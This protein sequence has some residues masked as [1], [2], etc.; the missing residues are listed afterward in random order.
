MLVLGISLMILLLGATGY[1]GEASARELTRRKLN[2]VP[3]SRQDIDYSRFDVLLNYLKT[4][5]PAFVINAAGYTG[6]R[7]WM[8]RDRARRCPGRYTMLPQ[9][10]ARPAPP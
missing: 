4:K 5:K 9:T 1:I 6:K 8:P 3:L 10:I 2:F 7:T